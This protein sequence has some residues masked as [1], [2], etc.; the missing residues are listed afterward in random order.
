MGLK[1]YDGDKPYVFASYCHDDKKRVLPI[2]GSLLEE[3]YRVWY[4][5]AI[6][7]TAEWRKVINHHI[8]DCAVFMVFVT[9][10]SMESAEVVKECNYAI[11]LHKKLHIIYLEDVPDSRLDKGIAADFSICERVNCSRGDREQ[12]A[13]RIRQPIE[14]LRDFPK[15]SAASREVHYAEDA[16]PEPENRPGIKIESEKAKWV[17]ET[18]A[19]NSSRGVLGVGD[20]IE[21]GRYPQFGS[22]PVPICWRVISIEKGLALV[23][24][25]LALDSVSLSEGTDL[26][27]WANSPIR[28]W[29]NG[30]FLAVAFT[31]AE[32]NLLQKV[33]LN[34]PG[35]EAT[36][37]RVFC[38][39]ADGVKKTMGLAPVRKCSATRYAL[40]GRRHSKPCCWWLR[41]PG[42]TAGS[43][44]YVTKFGK[45]A[46]KGAA[47]PGERVFVRPALY[48][49]P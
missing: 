19:A 23:V 46:F 1:A 39:T 27:D 6:P 47:A 9:R 43:A 3:G 2:I 31:A 11:N 37:D 18:N 41:T 30:G 16:R 22:E 10:A 14:E 7:P 32:Q 36:E 12:F 42:K 40:G 44:V 38:L 29:L 49:R 24:S 33:R 4:D 28:K 48:V 26:S 17:W 35:G 20:T 15:P 8:Q 34:N 45:I 21:L 25:E 13:V 5:G